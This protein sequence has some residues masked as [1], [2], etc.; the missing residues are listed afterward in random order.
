MSVLRTFLPPGFDRRVITLPPGSAR[1]YVEGE[2][3]DA[4][5]VI[6]QGEIDLECSGGGHRTFGRGDMLWFVGLSLRAVHNRG[7]EPAV[8]VAVSRHGFSAG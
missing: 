7:T 6:E 2:W 8:L 3:R 5:V 4:L 1:P